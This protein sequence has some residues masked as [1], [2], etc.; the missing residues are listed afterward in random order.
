M[1]LEINKKRR[2]NHH[3]KVSKF[4]D[5]LRWWKKQIEHGVDGISFDDI[6]RKRDRGD[7]HI[8]TD[9][10]TG[11]G[12]GG[13]VKQSPIN[14]TGAWFQ[15]KWSDHERTELFPHPKSPDI[16]WKEMAAVVTAALIWGKQ[17]RGKSVTFWID[18]M[19]VVFSCIKRKCDFKR[20][21]VMA[22]IRI[23]AE[24]ANQMRFHPYFI[25]IKGKDNLTADA[26]SRFDLKRFQ[27][28]TKGIQMSNT[29]TECKW[30]LDAILQLTWPK[31]SDAEQ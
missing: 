4:A 20:D 15:F 21:D 17:W 12:M 16:Y 2:F 23:L 26:L 22:M 24:C 27:A 13:W 28:D 11:D 7:I 9:A 29:P 25:H 19:G 10:S 1:E 3:L 18:N 8:L 5:D 30:A 31:E 6:L 14:Q